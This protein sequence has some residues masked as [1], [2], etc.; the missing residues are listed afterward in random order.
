MP[1]TKIFG[2]REGSAECFGTAEKNRRNS[3]AFGF[4]GQE[5]DDE[6]QGAG[7][8]YAF[9]YRIHDARLGRFMSID[10]LSYS[11]SFLSP[12]AFCENSPI[13][14]IEL[15]GLE[16]YEINDKVVSGRNISRNTDFDPEGDKGVVIV[17]TEFGIQGNE[18]SIAFNGTSST[19]SFMLPN[20]DATKSTGPINTPVNRSIAIAPTAGS[21][22]STPIVPLPITSASPTTVTT[23]TTAIGSL[24]YPS[25]I[26]ST[27]TVAPSVENY[28]NGSHVFQIITNTTIN[29]TVTATSATSFGIVIRSD[30][31][32]P[33]LASLATGLQAS[34]GIPTRYQ[35]VP[36][37]ASMSLFYGTEGG[38]T[39]NFSITV[40]YIENATTSRTTTSTTN[41]NQVR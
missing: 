39:I 19:Y 9:E 26:T 35:V 41:Y 7:N 5:R 32:S 28:T 34:T 36:F 15:E 11:Y 10:P 3:Y 33:G 17:N 18:G 2:F 22:G 12:Y 21:P 8:S 16:K 37:L 24:S 31:Y 13:N 1:H 20:Y 38:S 14:A 29:E 23:I 25:T 6:I 4:N 40:N 30:S 27:T